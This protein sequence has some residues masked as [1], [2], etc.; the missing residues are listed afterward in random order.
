MSTSRVTG[1]TCLHP[2]IARQSGV[3][4]DDDSLHEECTECSEA[5]NLGRVSPERAAAVRRD[6]EWELHVR[7]VMNGEE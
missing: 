5:W 6:V 2:K 3:D 1:E 4:D 7:R